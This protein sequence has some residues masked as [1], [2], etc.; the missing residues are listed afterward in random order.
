MVSVWSVDE[1]HSVPEVRA[2]DSDGAGCHLCWS[3]GATWVGW[4]QGRPVQ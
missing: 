3:L 2:G 1:A 4:G